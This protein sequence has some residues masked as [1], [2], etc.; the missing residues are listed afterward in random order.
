MKKY[1]LLISA[2]LLAG[3][4]LSQGEVGQTSDPRGE[5]SA[6]LSTVSRT[7][8][9]LRRDLRK[10]ASPVCGGYY[11]HDVNRVHL[12]EKYVSGLDFSSSGL[13]DLE[14]Q[15]VLEA[16][17][18]EVVLRG[19]LGPLDAYGTRPFIVSDAWRGMPGQQVGA[20]DT[21]YSVKPVNIT[22]VKAPCASMQ[23]KK[24]NAT[25]ATLFHQL[26]VS[27]VGHFVNRGWLSGR[28]LEHGALVA[29]SLGDGDLVS[30]SYEQVLSSRQVF[31]HLPE[32]VGVCQAA[33]VTQCPA[34]Q[35]HPYVRTADRCLVAQPCV[36]LGICSDALP[37]CADGYQAVEYRAG[38]SACPRVECDPAWCWE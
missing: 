26:D 36:S 14:Q 28:A 25:A 12:S 13:G 37:S 30:G 23:A 20:A 38:P 17:D 19:K 5:D 1:S 22:C 8:V 10:C 29:G 15:Q 27:P 31:V 21:F 4:G 9:L 35:E 7:L 24:A 2:V 34:G 6:E 32:A 33:L 18:G 11:V 3:C 16:D